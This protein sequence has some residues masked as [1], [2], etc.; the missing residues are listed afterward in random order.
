MTAVAALPGMTVET[1]GNMATAVD[2]FVPAVCDCGLL[3]YLSRDRNFRMFDSMYSRAVANSLF[4]ASSMSQATSTCALRRPRV[5]RDVGGEDNGGQE[6]L[7]RDEAVAGRPKT[8]GGSGIVHC[9]GTSSI[10][11]RKSRLVGSAKMGLERE[12]T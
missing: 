6:N 11:C 3:V 5:E 8:S 4:A 9:E 10:N 7:L 12:R 2:A 1:S